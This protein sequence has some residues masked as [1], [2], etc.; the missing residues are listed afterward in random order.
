MKTTTHR[1]FALALVSLFAACGGGGDDLPDENDETP[2]T[3]GCVI[4]LEG[5]VAGNFSCLATG[6]RENGAPNSVIGA[7][8]TGL[9][10]NIDTIGI[11][12]EVDGELTRRTYTADDIVAGG[13]V[14]VLDGGNGYVVAI[15]SENDMGTIQSVTISE[16]DEIASEEGTVVWEIHG[17]FT[18]TLVNPQTQKTVKMT[19]RF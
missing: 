8:A 16:L 19:A 3:T 4:K 10:G 15:G 12:L 18:A 1:F 17:T 5:E 11:A 13:A 2:P 7:A 6:G 14:V 9:S